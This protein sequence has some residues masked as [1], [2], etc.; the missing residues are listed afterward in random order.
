[1]LSLKQYGMQLVKDHLTTL[2]EV[3]RVCWNWFYGRYKESLATLL[4][5]F[6]AFSN[7]FYIFFALGFVE[8]KF[9]TLILLFLSIWRFCRAYYFAFYIIQHYGYP[10][11]KFSGLLDFAYYSLKNVRFNFKKKS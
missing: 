6:L 7:G 10:Y 5:K 2:S 9:N 1:M 8:F 3:M 11:Y 4:K